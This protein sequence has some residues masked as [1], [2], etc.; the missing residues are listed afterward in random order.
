MACRILTRPRFVY[1]PSIGHRPLSITSTVK[2]VAERSDYLEGFMN[3]QTPPQSTVDY[4]SSLPWTRKFLENQ[5]Y[6]VI[7]FF[8]RHLNDHT[9]ENRFFAQTVNSNTTVPHLLALQL[10]DLESP[11]FTSHYGHQSF[12]T[13]DPTT[14]HELICLVSLGRG[15]D[16]HPSIVH[17]GF[18]GVI[19]D[20]IMRN[21]ILLH[22]NNTCEPGPRDIHF[23][24]N[25]NIS[26]AA[27]VI[28][29]G[30]FLVR[31]NLAGREGR[32]WFPKA[33]IVNSDDVV[34][35]SADSTWVT[36]KRQ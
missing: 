7:P 14:P 22:N 25:M 15:L 26:Y 33:E 3:S 27:P 32:K 13:P 16:S 19:F 17:G 10:K 36:A 9:G 4:F 6:K 35:T 2:N 24:V 1:K 18:Q 28:T 20:E 29:P 12:N 11:E 5:A 31:S 23:T 30:V 8:S 34:L 21:L